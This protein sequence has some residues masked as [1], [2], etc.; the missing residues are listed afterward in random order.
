M[1]AQRLRVQVIKARQ[2]VHEANEIMANLPSASPT[3]SAVRLLAAA[4]SDLV[5]A[6]DGVVYVEA[7]PHVPTEAEQSAEKARQAR[8]RL[9]ERR[10]PVVHDSAK[11]RER[12]Q[13][14]LGGS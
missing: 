14:V 2:R 12:L 5:E 4:V 6:V 13:H 10:P 1:E 11:V 8:E 9:D 3:K 7:P